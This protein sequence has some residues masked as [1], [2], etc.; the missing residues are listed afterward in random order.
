MQDTKSQFHKARQ[1]PHLVHGDAEKDTKSKDK[2][3]ITQRVIKYKTDG[4][5]FNSNTN[6]QEMVE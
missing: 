3:E 1:N 4:W 6:N 2:T 5:I